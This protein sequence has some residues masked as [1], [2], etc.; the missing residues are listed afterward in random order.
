MRIGLIVDNPKRDLHGLLLLAWHLAKEGHDTYLV[1]MY[2]QAFDVCLLGLQAVLAN[3]ARVNNLDLL[4]SYKKMGVR[5]YVLDTEGGVLSRDGADEP[6]NWALMSAKLGLNELV[7]GY[8]FWG[9][10]L[11]DVFAQCGSFKE[12]ALH[13]TGCPRYDFCHPRWRPM[14]SSGEKSYVL[15]NTNFS[16]INPLFGESSSREMD[17]FVRL[18]W[19]KGYVK[20]LYSELRS[21]F[22]RYIE[23]IKTLAVQNKDRMFVV[24]PHPFEKPETYRTHLGQ[25]PNVQVKPEGNVLEVISGADCVVHLNCGSAVEALLSEKLP[26]SLEFLNTDLML[27]HSPL[28]SE[29][30]YKANSIEDACWAIR[31]IED[32]KSKLDLAQLVSRHLVPWFHEPD[33]KASERVA[34]VLTQNEEFD[35]STFRKNIKDVLYR[36]SVFDKKRQVVCLLSLIFG[37]KL[38][39]R[40]L[41][42]IWPARKY[43]EFDLA[44]ISKLL[45]RLQKLTSSTAQVAASH[46][47]SPLGGAKLSAIR[48]RRVS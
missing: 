3:Y 48:L 26:I 42:I 7:D 28:P 22:P 4:R 5:V 24:R 38:L 44:Q 15:I 36:S 30:S 35:K 25:L 19:K 17:V 46:A 12:A 31:S 21:V 9:S 34:A 37:T 43:K 32:A 23:A 20:R 33:G 47:C 40:I 45:A 6:R 39:T 1:P 13:V 14:I 18:G 2:S 16:A 10:N 27:R 11:R 41:T 29:L 8:C